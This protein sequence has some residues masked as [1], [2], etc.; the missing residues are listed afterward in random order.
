MAETTNEVRKEIE[1]RKETIEKKPKRRNRLFTIILVV[2]VIAGAIFGVSKFIY[3]QSHETTDDAQISANIIPIIPRIPGYVK[4]VRVVENQMVRKGDTLLIID[5]RDL[6]VRLDQ[7]MA[8]L[9]AAKTNMQSAKATTEAARSGINTSRQAVD[10]IDAQIHA[11]EVNLWRATQ[12]YQRYSNLIKDQTITQQQYEQALAA[13]QSAERQLEVLRQQKQQAA[14]QSSQV[15]TQSSATATQ[16]GM[17]GSGIKQREADVEAAKLNLSYVAITAQESGMISKVNLQPGQFVQAGQSYFSLVL[18]N[19]LWVTANFK[20]TQLGRMKVGLPVTVT[21][22]AFPK[23]EFEARLASFS[24]ATGASTA[25][26]PPDNAT[27]NFVKVVQRVPIRIEFTNAADTLL[28]QL[29]VGMS[30]GVDVHLQ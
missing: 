21:V 9:D 5:D 12:D 10:V 24:A 3:A 7:A 26:I 20:E 23:H 8:A 14:S 22:D 15:A 18:N 19:N 1:V 17:A 28:R 25:L 13:K 29:R 4:E 30:A 16:I 2:L 27:G 6:Q 11:A